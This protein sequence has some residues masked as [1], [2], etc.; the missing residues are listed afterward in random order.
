VRSMLPLV[1]VV[2]GRDESDWVRECID[3]KVF[4]FNIEP[5]LNEIKMF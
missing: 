5:R 2:V 3:F 4:Y 1:F